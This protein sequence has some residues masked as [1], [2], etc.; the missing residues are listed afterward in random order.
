MRSGAT[1]DSYYK[2]FAGAKSACTMQT[3][4]RRV[5]KSYVRERSAATG[6]RVR[7][8]G[9]HRL[10]G[11]ETCLVRAS[12]GYDAAGTRRGRTYAGSGGGLGGG[13]LSTIRHPADWGG[14][15]NRERRIGVHAQEV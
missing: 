12:G 3:L 13:T 4:L 2:G 5:L 14:G 9:G 11:S 10:G 6:A 7:G 1:Q 15:G 8:V